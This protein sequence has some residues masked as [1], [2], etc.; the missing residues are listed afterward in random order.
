MFPPGLARGREREH[1]GGRETGRERGNPLPSI[2][3][4]VVYIVPPVV[5]YT[6]YKI[7]PFVQSVLQ[8]YI[9][10]TEYIPGVCP[11]SFQAFGIFL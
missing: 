8:L 5:Y 2:F 3:V 6:L 10:Y 4:V 11:A 1:E 9:D 7:Q